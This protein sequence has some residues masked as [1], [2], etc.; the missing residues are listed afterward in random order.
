MRR[1]CDACLPYARLSDPVFIFFFEDPR[2]FFFSN[3]NFCPP[4]PHPK[5]HQKTFHPPKPRAGNVRLK[6]LSVGLSE[7][8]VFET[9]Y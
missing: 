9:E 5:K 3:V 4:Q 6:N 8:D 7:I 1:I 2:H